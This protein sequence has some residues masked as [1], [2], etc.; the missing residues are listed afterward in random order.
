MELETWSD[1]WEGYR[2]LAVKHPRMGHWC[3]YVGVP[4]THEYH[5]KD[6]DDVP[7]E[8]HGG[9]T[10]ASDRAPRKDPDGLWYLGF[11]CAHC[12]DLIPGIAN[13]VGAPYTDLGDTFKDLDFVKRECMA[14]A[15]QFKSA[16]TPT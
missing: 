16:E 12:G 11:D 10:Y 6:Y 3:G 4:D 7:V 14:L 8:V 9:L 15:A 13:Y 5:G 2:L 1:E